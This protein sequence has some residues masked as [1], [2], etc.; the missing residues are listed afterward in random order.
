M[1]ATGAEAPR[2][3]PHGHSAYASQYRCGTPCARGPRHFN[4]S[5]EIYMTT[6]DDTRATSAPV[7]G[8]SRNR[9]LRRATSFRDPSAPGHRGSCYRV[10]T[11][12][13]CPGAPQVFETSCAG[14]ASK[15]TL[16][17]AAAR[18]AEATTARAFDC[19]FYSLPFGRQALQQLPQFALIFFSRVGCS[20]SENSVTPSSASSLHVAATRSG[21]CGSPH[22]VAAAARRWSWLVIVVV[23]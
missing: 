18:A 4:G 9:A 14:T 13:R 17:A 6:P 2:Q 16:K 12:N 21:T 15:V 1:L 23:A 20:G 11:L 3:P 22:H 19:Y 7:W 8:R 10:V 5:R